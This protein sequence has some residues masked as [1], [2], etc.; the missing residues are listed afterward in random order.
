MMTTAGNGPLPWL[1]KAMLPF[2]LQLLA[3]QKV[4]SRH[5]LTPRGTAG[6]GGVGCWPAAG[7]SPRQT[8]RIGQNHLK[9]PPGSEGVR[10]ISG[11][12]GTGLGSCCYRPAPRQGDALT[13]HFALWKPL[14]PTP[15]P[16]RRGG[17]SQ[18]ASFLLPLSASGRGLRRSEDFSQ[19][20]IKGPAC[21]R[22]GRA[23]E[24]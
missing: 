13:G 14:P 6:P 7:D 12:R 17:A 24:A 2:K 9:V 19:R 10:D 21:T 22:D 23:G 1:G 15:S 20:R 4:T 18:T 16:K 3:L 5:S 11:P 8:T